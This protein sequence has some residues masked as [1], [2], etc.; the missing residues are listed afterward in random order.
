MSR[1]A[2]MLVELKILKKRLE[3]F[4]GIT[5]NTIKDIGKTSIV[6]RVVNAKALE[7]KFQIE[8]LEDKI[9]LKTEDKKNKWL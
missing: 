1:N 4:N 6:A 7:V 9:H 8:L 3:V 5:E 2:S